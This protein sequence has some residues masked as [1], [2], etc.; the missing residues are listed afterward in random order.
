LSFH[1]VLK[2]FHI[3]ICHP[4]KNTLNFLAPKSFMIALYLN[5]DVMKSS[6]SVLQGNAAIALESLWHRVAAAMEPPATRDVI[7]DL[8]VARKRR[9]CSGELMA[10][11]GCG[12]ETTCN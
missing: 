1:G 7:L 12:D 4:F 3:C 8:C 9:H 10:S 2:L 6:I 5:P 11:C